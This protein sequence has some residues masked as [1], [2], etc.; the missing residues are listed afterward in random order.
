[1]DQS[2]YNGGG[3]DQSYDNALMAEEHYAPINV[4]EDG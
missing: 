4:K 1:M 3:N 2:E